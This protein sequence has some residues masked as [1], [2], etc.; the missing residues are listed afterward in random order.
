MAFSASRSS[1]RWTARQDLVARSMR[2]RLAPATPAPG[3]LLP[4]PY[5]RKSRL[6][7]APRPIGPARSGVGN[8]HARCADDLL[9]LAARRQELERAATPAEQG[10]VGIEPERQGLADL[11]GAI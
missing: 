1:Q 3:A 5:H 11:A 9:G 8:S 2:S 4:L 10:A 7:P 6:P